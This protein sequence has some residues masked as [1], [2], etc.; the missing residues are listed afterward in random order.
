MDISSSHTTK[1]LPD[2]S[3]ARSLPARSGAEPSSSARSTAA[4]PAIA[5][6][7]PRSCE[8][9]DAHLMASHEKAST[10]GARRQAMGRVHAYYG[11]KGGVGTSTVATSPD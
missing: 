2:C 4:A 1:A 8:M 5:S 7:V 3:T 11:A 9:A 6:P 10:S